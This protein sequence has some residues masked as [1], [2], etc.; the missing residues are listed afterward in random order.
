MHLCCS[1]AGGGL[2][3][4]LHS[5]NHL[6]LCGLLSERR[7]LLR[8]VQAVLRRDKRE[9]GHCQEFCGPATMC[10]QFS[11]RQC[12]S[13]RRQGP[14]MTNHSHAASITAGAAIDV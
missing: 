1:M 6:V 11:C 3:S 7:P 13:S 8:S 12:C 5:S 9:E 10:E 2:C 14:T 4:G